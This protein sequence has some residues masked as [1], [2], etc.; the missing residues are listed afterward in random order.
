MTC[1]AQTP[2]ANGLSLMGRLTMLDAWLLANRPDKFDGLA[3]PAAL[4]GD[5]SE[6]DAASAPDPMTA[7]CFSALPP[8]AVE[9][10]E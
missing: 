1:L 8:P 5:Q 4:A 3:S 9:G 2:L 10:G 7:A 6:P